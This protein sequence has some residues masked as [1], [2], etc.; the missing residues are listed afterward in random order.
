MTRPLSSTPISI[1][2]SASELG[3][4]LLGQRNLEIAIRALARDGL[5]VLED[6]VEHAVLDRL[7]QKMVQDAYQLQARKDSPFNYN[8]GNIQQDPPMT[9]DWFSSDIYTNPI[10]IQVTSTALGPKP[11]LRFVSGNTA[12]PPTEASPPVSQPTHNDADFD[13]PSIPFALVVNVPLVT[14]TPENGST[15]VWLGTHNNTTIADQEGEHG[16]RASGRIKKHLLDAR[17]EIRPPSQPVVNKGSII[18]RDLRLWHGGKPNLTSE[19]RVMLAMIH[20]APWYRNAME[21]EFAEELAERLSPAKTGLDVAAKFIAAEHLLKNY[22]NRSFGNA[23]DFDQR[24]KIE[25]V[26]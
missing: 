17:G 18:I 14:M 11:S 8:K 3:S 1:V 10:V 16:D 4:G 6:M 26:F 23:Y 2:P 15:E 20:F 13:H 22:M 9:A 25:G 7:N 21:V 12:L 19:P 5:V 24:D